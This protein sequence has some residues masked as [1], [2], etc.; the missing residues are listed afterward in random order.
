ML[1]F[2]PF[3]FLNLIVLAAPPNRQA[4]QDAPVTESPNHQQQGQQEYETKPVWSN[5]EWLLHI[6][7]AISVCVFKIPRTG[8]KNIGGR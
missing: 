5:L 7:L 3:L 6:F 8:Y 4:A 2:V 1:K